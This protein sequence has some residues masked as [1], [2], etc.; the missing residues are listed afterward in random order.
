[1]NPAP[2]RCT[3]PKY[4]LNIYEKY[5]IYCII[6]ILAGMSRRISGE[7]NSSQEQFLSARIQLVVSQCDFDEW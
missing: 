1:M 7:I 6:C 4:L 5:Y 3:L 2:Y